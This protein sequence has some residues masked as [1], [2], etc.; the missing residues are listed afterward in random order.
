MDV[1]PPHEPIHYVRDFLLHLL[2]IT[3]GLLIALGLEKTVEHIHNRH[4]VHEA[5]AELRSE[6]AENQ[7]GLKSLLP[8]YEQQIAEN[9]K[10]LDVLHKVGDQKKAGIN[11]NGVTLNQASY[12]TAQTDGALGLMS[13]SESKQFADVYSLQADFS[14]EQ[15]VT[16]D[17][18]AP[19]IGSLFSH[20]PGIDKMTPSQLEAMDS[21]L[22]AYNGHLYMLNS[23]AKQLDALYKST[24]SSF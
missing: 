3:V 10:L 24:L 21:A 8:F 15:D 22:Q 12:T 4:L 5:E 1:H 16:V 17:T 19:L 2:T 7:K 6:L 13:Y 9:N 18:A 20:G 14:R 23:V 11:F